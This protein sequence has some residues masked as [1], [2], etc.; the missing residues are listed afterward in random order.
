[1]GRMRE[2]MWWGGLALLITLAGCS[3]DPPES[4]REGT[5]PAAHGDV[6]DTAASLARGF[7]DG[8][9]RLDVS[10]LLGAGDTIG[11]ARA[12]EARS[13]EFPVDHGPHPRVHT[14]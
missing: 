7:A 12:V 1:M 8:E 6:V 14:E 4:R 5:T 2:S 11:Y 13:F 3:S 9:G 10:T